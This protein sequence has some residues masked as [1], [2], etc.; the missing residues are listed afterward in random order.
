MNAVTPG[1][2]EDY[3]HLDDETFRMMVRT[4][5]EANYPPEIRNPTKRLHFPESKV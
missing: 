4:W 2:P 1:I 5:V 3:N